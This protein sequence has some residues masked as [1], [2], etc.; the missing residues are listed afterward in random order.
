MQKGKIL[1]VDYGLKRVG[2]AVTDPDRVVV[3]PRET[4][5][6]DEHLIP[7]LLQMCASERIFVVLFGLPL[8]VDGTDTKQ[9]VITREFAGRFS[10]ESGLEILFQDEAYTTFE[11]EQMIAERKH[12]E[13]DSL[14]AMKILEHY[15]KKVQE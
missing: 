4:L 10:K 15:L 1:G 13:K 7:D 5:R 12:V 8:K 6:N 11:A 3:F 9:S 14:S 2:L